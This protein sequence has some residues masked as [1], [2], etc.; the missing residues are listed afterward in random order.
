VFRG[1]LCRAVAVVR[2]EG[3]V[4]TDTVAAWFV[5]RHS[6]PSAEPAD[7]ASRKVEPSN[8]TTADTQALFLDRLDELAASQGEIRAMLIE[9]QRPP[10]SS[11]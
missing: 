7:V 1:G 4:R 11:Q 3:Q 2:G 9:L 6:E 5:R 8:A 10:T